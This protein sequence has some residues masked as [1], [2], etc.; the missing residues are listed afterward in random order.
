MKFLVST[1][2]RTAISI[3]V[4]EILRDAGSEVMLYIIM[5]L[6][7]QTTSTVLRRENR[8]W[9]LLNPPRFTP[10]NWVGN[11]ESYIVYSLL[12]M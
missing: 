2:L 1:A 10:E 5:T 12:I 9:K 4:A 3:H 11:R 8:C 6:K 7:L